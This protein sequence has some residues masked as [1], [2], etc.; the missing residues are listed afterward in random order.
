MLSINKK[1]STY[2]IN[3]NSSKISKNKSI[4]HNNKE[5]ICMIKSVK[6][7]FY[8]QAIIKY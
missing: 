6:L 7:K 3:K 2:Q 4:H 5:K 1:L 8:N